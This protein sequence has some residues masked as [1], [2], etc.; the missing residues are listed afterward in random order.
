MNDNH[1]GARQRLE[2]TV[3]SGPGKTSPSLRQAV[4]G[5]EA[6]MPGELQPLVEKIRRHA[7]KITDEDIDSLKVQYREE[8]LFEIIVSA[9]LGA[10][11]ER[12]ESG[13]KA[14]EAEV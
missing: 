4:A 13:L 10:S 5:G 14:L 8:E 9:S 1:E 12:L 11:L 3:L 6:E 7:Y 2:S